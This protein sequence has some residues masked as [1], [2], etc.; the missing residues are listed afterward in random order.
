MLTVSPL[1]SSRDS[2]AMT[3]H[4]VYFAALRLYVDNWRWQDVPFYLRTGKRMAAAVSEI[5]IRFRPVPH[6][7]FPASASRGFDQQ[8]KADLWRQRQQL[9][10]SQGAFPL[11]TGNHR[12]A[13]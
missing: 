9:I 1:R 10:I 3:R 4:T 13:R 12:H 2:G 11:R 5:S 6:R 8:W 7:A